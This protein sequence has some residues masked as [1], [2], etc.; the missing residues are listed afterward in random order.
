MTLWNKF[1]IFLVESEKCKFTLK[2]LKGII[3]GKHIP[4]GKTL[5]LMFKYKDDIVIKSKIDGSM[6]ICFTKKQYEILM[7]SCMK[8]DVQMI[9]TKN[10]KF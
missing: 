3:T 5:C 8:A 9:L 4:D 2:E 1:I 7:S 6:L 10:K